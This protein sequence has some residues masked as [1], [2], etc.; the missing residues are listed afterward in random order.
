ME[1]IVQLGLPLFMVGLF[2]EAV[3]VVALCYLNWV[4]K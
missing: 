2:G 3:V 1:T 4:K